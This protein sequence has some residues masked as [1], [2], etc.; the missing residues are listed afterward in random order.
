MTAMI[1]QT[2]TATLVEH[3]APED[4][5]PVGTFASFHYR[6]ASGGLSTSGYMLR[7]PGGWS[8]SPER[9]S[10]FW[11]EMVDL[12]AR[13]AAIQ[14]R[15][16]GSTTRFTSVEVRIHSTPP[17]DR[18]ADRAR[19]VKLHHT[20]YSAAERLGIR[21]EGASHVELVQAIAGLAEIRG[22]A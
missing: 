9:P 16:P 2:L 17:V 6:L 11:A 1:E 8:D 3:L 5:P 13:N 21:T 22:R 14:Q 19:L 4:E 15:T 10:R 7:T 12:N 20:V 18:P